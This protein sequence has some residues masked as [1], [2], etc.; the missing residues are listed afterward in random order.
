MT[1]EIKYDFQPYD[2]TPGE[3]FNA[4]E[5][6]YLNALSLTDDQGYS[7]ADHVLER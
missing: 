1:A 3:P 6:R 4:F 2:C 5:E 7:L